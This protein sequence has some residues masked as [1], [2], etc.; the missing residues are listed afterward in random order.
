MKYLRLLLICILYPSCVSAQAQSS[1]LEYRPF[2]Q[3]G[4]RWETQ[5]GFIMENVYCNYID[6]DTLINGETWKK[7]FN[8]YGYPESKPSYFLA[9]RDVGKKVYAIA[10]SS[11]TPRLL[12]DF[13]LRA[14]DIVKCGIE[15]NAFCCLLDTGEKQDSLFGFPFDTFLRVE[16]IDTINARGYKHRRYTLKL[17]DA[18]KEYLWNGDDAYNQIIWV[19]G[20]GSGAG[21]FLPW[22]SLPPRDSF[23]QNCVINDNSLFGYPDFY[24]ADTSDAIRSTIYTKSVGDIPFDLSGRRVAMPP[25]KGIYIRDGKKVAVK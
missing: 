19:E 15:G 20:V 16:R 22:I 7:V 11:R 3:D 13:D 17:L 1:R 25:S 2:A 24:D 21:P 23:L 4:K 9:I 5:V 6:G 8:V 12:Y 18:Y 10:K 14:G